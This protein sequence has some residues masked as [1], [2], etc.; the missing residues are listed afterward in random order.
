METDYIDIQQD[1]SYAQNI[2]QIFEQDSR[3]FSRALTEEQEAT[4]G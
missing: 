2:S 3:R 1:I 4:A